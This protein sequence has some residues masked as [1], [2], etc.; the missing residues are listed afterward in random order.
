MIGAV[1]HKKLKRQLL[2]ICL[3]L[4]VFGIHTTEAA[5]PQRIVSLSPH[6]TEAV[7]WLGAGS[8]L[9]GRDRFSD[10]PPE[11]LAVPVVG[12]A[13]SL[14]IEALAALKPDLVLLW[15]APQALK[16]QLAQL[17]LP[18]F[19][20]NPQTVE[21]IAAELQRLAL[22]LEASAKDA[23]KELQQQVDLLAQPQA[24][25]KRKA[26]I[27]VQQQPPIA[28]G[29][30]DPLAGSL[31]HCG[32]ENALSQTNAVINLSPEYL[33]AGHYDALID[34]T[35]NAHNRQK[36]PVFYPEADTLV[37]PG[38]RFPAALYRLCRQLNGYVDDMVLK[39]R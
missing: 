27:L 5:T 10:Y 11:A 14:N 7:F 33:W 13:Y 3:S 1:L 9:L 19:D 24:S 15:Q 39:K 2:A 22:L 28:L 31:W 21:Q 29:M 12:D 37:R 38:P 30:G 23:F 32:W 17:G 35:G 25:S 16:Q 26:L 8:R 6:L 4:G 20:S 34:F 18:I 36:K